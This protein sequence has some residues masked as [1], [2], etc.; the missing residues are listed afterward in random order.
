MKKILIPIFIVIALFVA[1]VLIKNT[2]TET[3]VSPTPQDPL[4]SSVVSFK[5]HFEEART[6]N[7]DGVPQTNVYLLVTY[8]DTTS[9]QKVIDTVNGS[10]SDLPGN[11]PGDISNTGKIQCYSAGLGQQYRIT[12]EKSSYRIERKLFEEALPD[13]SSTVYDWELV[14]EFSVMK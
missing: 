1:I 6:L 3:R 14:T 4:P 11:Y 13:P 8:A 9:E 12:R 10:C 7:P 2:R 5:W